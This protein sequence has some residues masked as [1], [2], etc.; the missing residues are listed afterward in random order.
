MPSVTRKP[1]A[2]R[3]QERQQRRE[4]L[5]RRLLDATE[6]LMRDGTSFTE[7]SVDRLATE[8][9]IS[10]ASFYI[11]F[12][13]KGHLLRRLADQ[14]FS[15]LATSAERWWRVAWQHNPDDLRAALAGVVEIY[16]RHQAVLVALNE[17][18]AYDPATA[19]T[20]R[21]LL[22]AITRRLIRVIEGGQAD[23][24]IR[25][26]LPAATTASALT[27]MVERV[28]QQNLPAEPPG[29]DPELVATL[30]QIVWGTL[31]LKTAPA[32]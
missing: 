11:Y 32:L 24:S 21:D 29:Y 31:Y 15:E 17:M 12:E 5:E 1:Q 14:L 20:Y 9:G 3:E 16:R 10:R 7:L 30:A 6:R 25:R 2:N 23:G 27:W 18:A 22:T 8:A 4:Q 26:E 13:D 28:C 19:Q